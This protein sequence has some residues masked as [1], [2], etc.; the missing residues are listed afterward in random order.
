MADV[1]VDQVGVWTEVVVPDMFLEEVSVEELPVVANQDLQKLEFVRGQVNLRPVANRLACDEV[2]RK[3]ADGKDGWVFGA[4]NRMLAA[5]NDIDA[6]P[7]FIKRE[8]LG[9]VII[10]SS[11]QARDLQL[12]VGERANDDYRGVDLLFASG[13]DDIPTVNVG[14]F[15]VDDYKVEPL[16]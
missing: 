6:G 3:V 7:Q 9:H 8:G 14:Q 4:A 12:Y 13:L 15:Q 10:G 5:V 16:G 1:D 11:V 2:E